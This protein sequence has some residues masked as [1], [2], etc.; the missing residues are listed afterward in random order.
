M[1]YSIRMGITSLNF[2]RLYLF[3]SFLFVLLS[4]FISS[5]W[6]LSFS[7]KMEYVITSE[8]RHCFQSGGTFITLYRSTKSDLR[9]NCLPRWPQIFNGVINQWRFP[10]KGILLKGKCAGITIKDLPQGMNLNYGMAAGIT[11]PVHAPS[12]SAEYWICDQSVSVQEAANLFSVIVIQP[13]TRL[14]C[15]MIILIATSRQRIREIHMSCRT[16]VLWTNSI[17]PGFKWI[18]TSVR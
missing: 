12:H 17:A 18:P 3:P 8:V 4:C 2:T 5:I 1:L 6:C 10:L 13:A 7:L 11:Q 14:T 9:P 16:V 15:V